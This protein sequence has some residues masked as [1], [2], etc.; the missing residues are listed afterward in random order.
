MPRQARTPKQPQILVKAEACIISSALPR[1]P[2]FLNIM[3]FD[4]N[5][6]DTL[7]TAREILIH[8]YLHIFAVSFLYYDHAITAGQEINFLWKK[9]KI[10]SSYWFFLNRYFAFFGNIVVVIMG[11]SN[12]TVRVQVRAR[13][14]ISLTLFSRRG[15][16]FSCK[17]Y[18]LFRQLVLI[19]NQVLVCILLTLRIYALYGRSLRILAYMGGSGVV[20]IAFSLWVMFGQKSAPSESGGGCH[21]GMSR[22]TAIRLAGA[23]EALFVYDSIIFALTFLKTWKARRDHSITGIG[24]PLISIIL[25]DGAIYF[26]IMALCNLSNIL[27]F[28]LLGVRPKFPNL[29]LRH[30]DLTGSTNI[31]LPPRRI[32]VTMMSRLM[33]NLHETA[34]LGI[35]STQAT[36]T[37]VD[38]VTQY[39]ADSFDITNHPSQFSEHT[40]PSRW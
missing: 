17:R 18:N 16:D 7:S 31:A 22:D 30:D 10:R 5:T 14:V 4:H 9:P 35:Y 39:A 8:N 40:P 24:I 34:D 33:L 15:Y 32:S 1:C 26:A 6:N 37:H 19:V 13:N 21:I 2:F 23:W 27:T 29:P 38:Y 3:S 25:R 28:Y 11:F 20:L 12:L 36:S